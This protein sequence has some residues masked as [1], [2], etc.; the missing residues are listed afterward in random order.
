MLLSTKD[1]QKKLGI[2]RDC[3]YRLFHAR[4][5]PSLKLGGRYYIEE[6][7]LQDFLD[8]YAYKTFEM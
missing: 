4:A 6:G 1:V 5:F 7:K 3:A 8:R 2:S